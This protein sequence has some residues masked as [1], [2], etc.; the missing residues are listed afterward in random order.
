MGV[1]FP[2]WLR[3]YLTWILPAL[4][5]VLFAV[6]YVEKF[7]LMEQLKLFWATAYRPGMGGWIVGILAAGTLLW[8]LLARRRSRR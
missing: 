2:P 7:G 5:L 8:R 3:G 4:I 1:K 6:G